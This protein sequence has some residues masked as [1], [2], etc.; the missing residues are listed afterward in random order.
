[1]RIVAVTC[2]MATLLLCSVSAGWASPQGGGQPRRLHQIDWLSYT[3]PIATEVNTIVSHTTGRV[4]HEQGLYC[5]RCSLTTAPN[6][7]LLFT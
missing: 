5:C 4:R 7:P 1:M 2:V 6:L 3:D